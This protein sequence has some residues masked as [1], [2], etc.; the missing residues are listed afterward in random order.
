M[1]DY[2]KMGHAMR[3]RAGAASNHVDGAGKKTSVEMPDNL[4]SMIAGGSARIAV[5]AVVGKLMPKKNTQAADP[6]VMVHQLRLMQ[7]HQSVW[8]QSTLS[9]QRCQLS[10]QQQV[11]QWRMLALFLQQ[12]VLVKAL[13]VVLLTQ[14]D[15]Q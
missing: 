11:Q 3:R 2:R 8:V 10:T 14:C 6:A 5:G 9:L 7:V 12:W 1:S 15:K 13:L 4:Q